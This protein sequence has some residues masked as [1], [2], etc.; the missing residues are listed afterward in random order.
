MYVIFSV[1]QCAWPSAEGLVQLTFSRTASFGWAEAMQDVAATELYML[2]HAPGSLLAVGW[3]FCHSN[4]SQQCP[5]HQGMC[6]VAPQV[7]NSAR[8]SS[9]GRVSRSKRWEWGTQTGEHDPALLWNRHL[10]PLYGV[11]LI[12]LHASMTYA[13]CGGRLTVSPSK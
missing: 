2:P 9:G 10:T 11:K 4:F 3:L 6:C 12:G 5:S 13:V 8:V 7:S 1:L